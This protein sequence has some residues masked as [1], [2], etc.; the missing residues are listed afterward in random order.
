MPRGNVLM[1]GLGGSGRRSVVKLAS[2]IAD[3]TLI[4]PEITRQY[5]HADWTEDMK[6]VLLSAGMD[7]KKT[8]LLFSDG[9]AKHEQFFE[10]IHYLLSSYDL[11]NIFAPEEKVTILDKMQSEAKAMVSIISTQQRPISNRNY[12]TNQFALSLII[13]T[14]MLNP[15]PSPSTVTSRNA[16][17]RSSIW[18]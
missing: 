9:Q 5:S 1:F 18:H 11:N 8:V 13:R 4:Q 3:C 17:R 7:Y 10:D 2:T 15:L 16:S 6:K 12:P 14:K